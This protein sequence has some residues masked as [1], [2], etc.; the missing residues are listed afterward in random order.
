MPPLCGAGR[1]ARTSPATRHGGGPPRRRRPVRLP[2]VR[3]VRGRAAAV[4][5]RGARVAALVA[6]RRRAGRALRLWH[7]P[8]VGAGR[9]R[10]RARGVRAQLLPRVRARVRA[11]L[12]ERGAAARRLPGR[13]LRAGPL[14]G[15]A[16][17][18]WRARRA[19]RADAPLR[20]DEEPAVPRV[21]L[22][23]GAAHGGALALVQLAPLRLVPPHLLLR[24]RR[25]PPGAAV[26][27]LPRGGR[28]AAAAAA[29]AVGARRRA[30]RSATTPRWSAARTR[31]A[32]CGSRRRRAAT[33]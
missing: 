12:R 16:V 18:D 6:R 26:P 8:D 14:R 28:A 7:L 5:V 22:L 25:R 2:D 30:A 3:L 33:T 19:A 24:P 11:R 21:P 27:R 4:P 10:R 9:R 32:G 23:R 1:A 29:A 15:A 31:R 17:R 13:R 20:G